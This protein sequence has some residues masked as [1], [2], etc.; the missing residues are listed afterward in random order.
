MITQ[1]D[2]AKQTIQSFNDIRKE[3]SDLNHKYYKLHEDIHTHLKVEEE[4]EDYKKELRE[5][6]NKSSN[7]RIYVAFALLSV[8]FTIYEIAKGIIQ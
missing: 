8:G 2:F 7:K 3:I 5:S 6:T 1:E 4:L